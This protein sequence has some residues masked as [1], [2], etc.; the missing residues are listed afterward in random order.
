MFLP[1]ETPERHRAE[2]HDAI[3]GFSRQRIGRQS[4]GESP[5]LFKHT[6]RESRQAYS[7]TPTERVA[8]PI[9]THRQRESPS[10]FKHTD[11]ESRQVYS[12]TPTER[13]AKPIQTHRQ[14]ESPSLF[15]HNQPGAV[16]L[17]ARDTLLGRFE[18]QRTQ[19][20]NTTIT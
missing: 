5:S 11:R 9:Q 18:L 20:M 16:S 13:V 14:R 8:K 2:T 12:N 17:L 7:N 10:L 19:G 6:D 1:Q 15:K 3:K 4:E